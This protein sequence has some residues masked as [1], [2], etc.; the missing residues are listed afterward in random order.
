MTLSVDFFRLIVF[1]LVRSKKER[2]LGARRKD[3]EVLRRRYEHIL[4]T[5][6]PSC[7]LANRACLAVRKVIT[8]P[9]PIGG[10]FSPHSFCFVAKQER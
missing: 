3:G 10:I 9:D 7:V 5:M 6:R 2:G 4:N 8:F 1:A